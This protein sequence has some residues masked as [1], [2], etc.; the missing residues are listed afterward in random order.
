MLLEREQ[1]PALARRGSRTGT[2]SAAAAEALT[3]RA[4]HARPAWRGAQQARQQRVPS[5]IVGRARSVFQQPLALLAGFL[6][7]L[8]Q[9]FHNRPPAHVKVRFGCHE[10]AT[11]VMVIGWYSTTTE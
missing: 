4:P 9:K 8:L 1:V 5:L 2:R 10:A 11:L 7:V 6:M 3:R